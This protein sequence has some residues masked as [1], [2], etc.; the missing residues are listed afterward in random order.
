MLKSTTPFE[1]TTFKRTSLIGTVIIWVGIW[2]ASAVILQGTSSFAQML[3]ILG[4]GV[5]WFVVV[6]PGAFFWTCPK[7]NH[8]LPIREQNTNAKYLEEKRE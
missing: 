1:S 4:S 8:S 2:V 5:F 7:S 6:V 3:P